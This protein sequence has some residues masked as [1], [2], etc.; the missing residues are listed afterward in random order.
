M[1]KGETLTLT[2][3]HNHFDKMILYPNYKVFVAEKDD[4]IIGTF[5]LLIMDNLAHVGTPSG[6]V[7]DVVV[8]QNYQGQGIGKTMMQFALDRCKD[9]GCYKMVFSSNLKRIEAHQF[10]ESLGFEKHGFSYR[11]NL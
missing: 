3:A 7:E 6:I 11:I 10:Y 9:F 1:D 2:D 5:A 4:L 8:A